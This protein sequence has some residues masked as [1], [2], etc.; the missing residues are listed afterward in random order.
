MSGNAS[1]NAAWLVQCKRAG[2]AV[3][4]AGPG[5]E[6]RGVRHRADM[7]AVAQAPADPAHRVLGHDMVGIAARADDDAVDLRRIAD[8]EAGLDDDAVRGLDRILR[9]RRR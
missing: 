5:Q 9:R 4:Q 1:L 2:M 3:E 7:G 8:E 6:E